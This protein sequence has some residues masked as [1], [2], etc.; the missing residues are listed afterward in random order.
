[1]TSHPSSP[2]LRILIADDHPVVREGL[3][4]ILEAAP[5]LIL[6]G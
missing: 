6:V 3:R 1:M 5:D 4:A 2:S